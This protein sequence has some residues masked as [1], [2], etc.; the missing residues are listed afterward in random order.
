MAKLFMYDFECSECNE[1]FEDLQDPQDNT[2]LPCPK[3]GSPSHRTISPVRLDWKMGTDSAGLPT[4]AAKWERIQRARAKRDNIE[5]PNLW[6][7]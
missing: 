2:A 7:H 4:A 1:C 3:C 6:M 5:G